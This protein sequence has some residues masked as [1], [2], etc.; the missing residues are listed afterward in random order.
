MAPAE[1]NP[2]GKGSLNPKGGTGKVTQ[3]CWAPG[4]QWGLDAVGAIGGKCQRRPTKGGGPKPQGGGRGR[5]AVDISQACAIHG[6]TQPRIN[7]SESWEVTLA[8]Q[9]V[10]KRLG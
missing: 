5:E 1:D 8:Q 6:T 9:V 2:H 3:V 7:R 4:Q 10:M